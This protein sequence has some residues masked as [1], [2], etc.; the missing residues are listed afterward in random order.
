MAIAL[1]ANL[2]SASGK[3]GASWAFNTSSAAASGSR[4]ILF[5]SWFTSTITVSSV[6]STSPSLTWVVD[7]QSATDSGEMVAFVSAD[8]P[9]GA[10]SG[11]TITV[12][13]SSSLGNTSGTLAAASFTGV[14]TGASGYL[15]GTAPAPNTSFAGTAWA[16]PS[17]TTGDLNALLVAISANDGV[18]PMTSTTTGPATEIHDVHD[19]TATQTLTSAYQV[20]TSITSYSIAGT[21]SATVGENRK[22]IVAY[23]ESAGAPISD[24]PETLRVVRSGIMNR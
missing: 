14:E 13:P 8:A 4:I 15:S 23:K 21:W 20:A 11:M 22:G 17:I 6:A 19:A 1:D 9:S 7:K 24:A 16:T 18:T 12:T 10:A 3:T 2:G 5:V